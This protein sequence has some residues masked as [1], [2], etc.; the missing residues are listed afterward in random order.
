MTYKCN[1][2]S[3]YICTLN[4]TYNR[5]WNSSYRVPWTEPNPYLNHLRPYFD[6]LFYHD[7]PAKVNIDVNLYC[8]DCRLW[9]S[10]VVIR[11]TVNIKEYAQQTIRW[12]AAASLKSIPHLSVLM[13]HGKKVPY[14]NQPKS[15][16][17]TTTFTH[18][19]QLQMAKYNVRKSVVLA[20]YDYRLYA[21]RC[22]CTF[23]IKYRVN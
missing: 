15:I 1:L 19:T 9:D 7:L 21:D 20:Q 14:Y 10:F 12:R 4:L 3:T 11:F 18:G 22:L 8:L 5:T 13:D 6:Y 23:N 2:N 16:V 17:C